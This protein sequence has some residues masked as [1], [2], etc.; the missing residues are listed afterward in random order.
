MKKVM[1]A[2][3]AFAA[4]VSCKSLKEE[5]D[6]VFHCPDGGAYFT[7][8]TE[9]YLIKNEG[10]ETITTIAELK[11]RYNG[12]PVVISGNTWIKGQVVSSDQS[13]NI[14]KEIFL[15]DATGA[16][17]LKMGKGNM[18]PEYPVGMWVFVRC[19][20]L[21]LGNYS[22]MA[23]LGF[24]PDNTPGSTYDTSYLDL[25]GLIDG[26]VFRS[27]IADPPAPQVISD[28]DLGAA[29]S[30]GYTGEIWGKLVTIKGLRY[31]AEPEYNTDAYKRIFV[32]LNI[33][34]YKDKAAN[35]NRMRLSTGTYGV[36][37]WALSKNK[38]IELLDAGNFDSATNYDGL[39][40]N[41]IF[42]EATGLTLKQTLRANA[43]G[44]ATSQ[45]FHLGNV[46]VQIRTSGFAK[47]ADAVIDPAIIGNLSERDGAAITATGIISLYDGS[48]QLTLVDDP[49]ISVVIEQL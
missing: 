8:V 29:L 6:P 39:G 13:G 47:F 34:P 10:L 48:A 2:L 36:N 49:S 32:F 19:D 31:G 26:H 18:F 38:F 40:M 4:L 5:W 3:C 25:Q 20:G 21:T 35:F 9:Q 45:Y 1:I 14:Y 7:P 43:T 27:V 37:T 17:D 41:E 24:A 11:S 30:R 28:N 12:S 23:Q 44:F 42:D 15:Q 46:P 16:I 22:G 33:D